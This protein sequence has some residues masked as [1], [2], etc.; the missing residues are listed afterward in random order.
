M[1]GPPT[2]GQ[3]PAAKAKS[4]LPGMVVKPPFI[5]RK[6]KDNLL[7]F[8]PYKPL[9]RRLLIDI[10]RQWVVGRGSSIEVSTRWVPGRR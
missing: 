2:G 10:L 5:V 7:A 1:P 3:E 9:D 6:S 4:P 8:S